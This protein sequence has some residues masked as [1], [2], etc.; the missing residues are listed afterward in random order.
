MARVLITG[1]GGFIGQ[2]LSLALMKSGWDVRGI[3]RSAQP[4]LLSGIEWMTGDILDQSFDDKAVTGSD[5]IIHLACLSLRESAEDPALASRI[6][7][8]GTLKVLEAARRSGVKRF[9]FTSTSQVYG[10]G[11]DLPNKESDPPRPDSTY[12]ASK[13]SAEVWC[14]A[15]RHMYAMPILI[16]RLFNVYGLS[17]DGTPRPTVETLFLQQIRDGGQPVITGNPQS[18]RDFIHIDDVVRAITLAV[19]GTGWEGP[20]NIGTGVFTTIQGLAFMTAQL[21][22]GMMLPEI[23]ECASP[24]VRFQADILK[25]TSKLEF[26]AEIDLGGGMRRLIQNCIKA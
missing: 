4:R 25:A 20:L 6:N 24:T 5:V 22:G 2:H 1:A 13:Y 3:G 19:L 17:A 10:G 18:G 11:S 8:E 16:L 7:T 14:E 23:L 9:V 26:Q 21:L 12:A 15:Y